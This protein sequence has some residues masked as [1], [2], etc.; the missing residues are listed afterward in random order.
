MIISQVLAATR[1]ARLPKN[2]LRAL[3]M[4]GDGGCFGSM[5]RVL[6]MFQSILFILSIGVSALLGW[7]LGVLTTGRCILVLIVMPLNCEV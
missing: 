4:T 1:S 7:F 6:S 3:H 5:L 2:S